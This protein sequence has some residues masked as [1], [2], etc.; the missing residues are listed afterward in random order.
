MSQVG[1]VWSSHVQQ[2]TQAAQRALREQVVRMEQA[3]AETARFEA[4]GLTEAKQGIDEMARLAKE[5]I[6]YWA[7]LATAWRALAV[8]T[9]GDGAD[10]FGSS[11]QAPGAAPVASPRAESAESSAPEKPAT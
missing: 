9:L 1:E 4:R 7:R 10:M 11:F 8:D 6:D 3:F 5:T 2:G